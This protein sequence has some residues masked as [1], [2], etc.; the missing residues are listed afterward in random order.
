MIRQH[1]VR[2]RAESNGTPRFVKMF[3]ALLG[4][5]A[6]KRNETIKENINK[7]VA[8]G[9]AEVKEAY[10]LALELD[11]AHKKALKIKKDDPP[12]SDEEESIFTQKDS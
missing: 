4:P 7:I 9:T 10:E 1:C 3:P 12:M 8:I 2:V 11:E 6:K 5:V